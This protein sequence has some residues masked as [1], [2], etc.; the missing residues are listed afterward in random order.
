MAR[1]F[2]VTGYCNPRLHYMVDI[3]GRLEKIR[4]LIDNGDYFTINRARQY[5]KTTTIKAL[6]E[7][8]AKEYI[9]I[10]LDFQKLSN[11]DFATEIIFSK[12]FARYLLRTV[13]NKKNPVN[14]FNERQLLHMEEMA[15]SEQQFTLSRLF[16]LLSDL[17]D[18]AQKPVVMII[19]E[20]DSATNNQVFLDFLAQLRSY[21]LDRETT[22]TFQSVILAGVA[23]VKNIRMKIRPH[24]EHKVNSPWNIAA[25]FSVDMSFDK[26]DIAGMLDQYEEDHHTGMDVDLIAGLICD[27]TAGYP[28]LVSRL[29][30][31]IDERIAGNEPFISEKAAWSREGYL[32]AEKLLISEKNTLF[33]SLTGKLTDYPELKEMLSTILFD[34]K[35]IP[36]VATNHAV[37]IA[38]IYGFIRNVQNQVRISNRIF[39]TVLYNHLLSEEIVGSRMYDSALAN[40]FR[41]TEGHRLNMRLVLENFV[42]AFGEVSQGKDERFLEEEGRK[43][44]MLYLKPIINGTGHSYVETR[45]RNLKRTDLVVDY[46][47]KQFVV[48]M[49]IWDGPKYHKE[50]ERQLAE[51]LDYYGLKEGYLLVFNFNKNKE[52]GLREALV[53]GHLLIEAFV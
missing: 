46:G 17:C 28:F 21:Y 19:D 26:A 48:E 3:S 6:A 45:T 8:I 13:R 52:T 44:F 10:S 34:G 1:R 49:K 25:D 2:N 38:A 51:Y 14:G 33:D 42:R 29:C 23:D 40:K 20:V 37:E 31:L 35:D 7:Y 22:A 27:S 9:V 47:G 53:D 16:E 41:F 18:T 36:Y 5:G 30:Q 39:E 32:E 43:Y 50:G 24:A 11:A 15:Q 4:G 12:A